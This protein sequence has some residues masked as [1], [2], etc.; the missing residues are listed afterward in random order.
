MSINPP[1]LL[2]IS[3][4]WE[5]PVFLGFLL[6]II[7][8]LIS[9]SLADF[10]KVFIFFISIKF[11]WIMMQ[12][13][14]L[15][16][17]SDK[18]HT[19]LLIHGLFFISIGLTLYT[20]GWTVYHFEMKILGI[21]LMGMVW[22][23]LIWVTGWRKGLFNNQ[24]TLYWWFFNSLLWWYII[25]FIFRDIGISSDPKDITI[26]RNQIK[27]IINFAFSF[28]LP[29]TIFYLFLKVFKK[30]EII[31]NN[32][33]S[34]KK[35]KTL[36]KVT[37]SKILGIATMISLGILAFMGIP[38]LISLSSYW[39]GWDDISNSMA[40]SYGEGRLSS[41]HFVLDLGN[42]LAQ[43]FFIILAWTLGHYFIKSQKDV[44]S[45]RWKEKFS[46]RS[47][48]ALLF[49]FF[50]LVMFIFTWT[51]L[52]ILLVIILLLVFLSVLFV[53]NL[54][55]V[56]GIIV[57]IGLL[58][59]ILFSTST[60][61]N[62]FAKD[63]IKVAKVFQNHFTSEHRNSNS[64]LVG[65][66]IETDDLISAPSFI[67]RLQHY[68]WGWQILTIDPITGI[69]PFS[70]TDYVISCFIDDL[71]PLPY[72]LT[73]EYQS[74]SLEEKKKMIENQ[75]GIT[76][77]LLGP[78]SDWVLIVAS[79]GIP[80]M[81]LYYGFFTILI[82]YFIICFRREKTPIYLGIAF[83]LLTM[84]A[85]GITEPNFK[86]VHF[87]LL[88]MYVLIF[89]GIKFLGFEIFIKKGSSQ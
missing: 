61:L 49:C 14:L 34:I 45:Q 19:L 39:Q 53:N 40:I 56:F 66:I 3:R 85:S 75:T 70:Y 52:L 73:Q 29:L 41:F 17:K 88:S 77:A 65:K 50:L 31:K 20:L 80:G 55:Y 59:S 43:G 48:I 27:G 76:R 12:Q 62:S 72:I 15:H 16:K 22:P 25:S 2:N 32:G 10:S 71:Y 58:L 13:S 28:S 82:G 79:G 18:K 36:N 84:L 87:H 38:S 1:S 60:Q 67:Y 21:L 23:L 8:T 35:I 46:L 74:V 37:I 33:K 78:H 86:D 68:I 51:K 83:A 63:S 24:E 42:I 30:K 64:T 54:R 69:G 4:F 6:F 47:I 57:S 5:R 9:R 11:F 81:I 26:A 44:I 89:M 7:G